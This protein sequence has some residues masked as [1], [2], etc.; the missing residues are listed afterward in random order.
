LFMWLL[1]LGARSMDLPIPLHRQR[2]ILASALRQEEVCEG[3]ILPYRLVV[4]LDGVAAV[5]EVIHGAGA[6]ELLPGP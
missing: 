3:R 5:D 2:F 4:E 6:A 1:L